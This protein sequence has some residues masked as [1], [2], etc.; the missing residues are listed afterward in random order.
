M[1]RGLAAGQANDPRA[2]LAELSE[3]SLEQRI[4]DRIRGLIIFE[5][6][7]ARQVAAARDHELSSEGSIGEP[8]RQRQGRLLASRRFG[9]RR[10]DGSRD[11][12]R[13]KPS[14]CRGARLLQPLRRRLAARET[15]ATDRRDP[16]S[17]EATPPP[18]SPGIGRR[19]GRSRASPT[20]RMRTVFGRPPHEVTP[21]RPGA[22]H[23]RSEGR[24]P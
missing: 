17:N 14:M 16:A 9:E 13:S 24:Q 15:P 5:A 1:K 6:V 23:P 4:R 20:R 21:R 12:H 18:P 3:T 19:R 11:E 7:A 8:L 10:R 22:E 2:Q